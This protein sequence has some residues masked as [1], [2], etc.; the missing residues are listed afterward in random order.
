MARRRSTTELRP[1]GL[2]LY[3]IN[4]SRVYITWEKF[5][6]SIFAVS[7]FKLP[8]DLLH[9]N[10]LLPSEWTRSDSNRRSPACKAGAFPLGHGPKTYYT[11]LLSEPLTGA[12]ERTRTSTP[13]RAIDPKSIASANSATS[14][15][16]VGS[17]LATTE[18][19]DHPANHTLCR[20]FEKIPPILWLLS[21][22]S[23]VSHRFRCGGLCLHRCYL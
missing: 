4:C 14:A 7:H 5:A 2:Q 20:R 15:C 3:C 18:F 21:L 8:A 12:D 6:N 10:F 11:Q 22:P 13:C 23:S 17:V 9:S 1:Q 19:G 16:P